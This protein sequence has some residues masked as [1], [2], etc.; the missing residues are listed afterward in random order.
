M[1]FQNRSIHHWLRFSLLLLIGVFVWANSSHV[2][3]AHATASWLYHGGNIVAGGVTTNTVQGGQDATIWLKVGYDGYINQARIYYT[4]NGTV[5]DGSYDTV[6]NGTKIT[7]TFDHTESDPG[8]TVAWWK[9]T[10]PAQAAGTYVR[11]KISTWHSGG[12]DIVYAESPTGKTINTSSEATT[13]AYYVGAYTTPTWVKD[14]TI[15]QVFIDR[16]FDGNT[17]NN[18]DCTTTTGGYCVNDLYKWNGGDLAGVQARLDYL[19]SLGVNTLWVTPIYEN[20]ITQIGSVYDATPGEIYNY[21]GY[22]AQD[23]FDVE[24]NF[25]TNANFTS[26]VTAAHAAGMKVI[27]DFVPNHSSNQHPYFKDASDNCTSSSYFRWYKFGNVNGQGQLTS[28]DNSKCVAGHTTWWG[29]NDTYANFFG[30]KEMPQID[31]DYGPAR[32]A[33]IDQALTWVNTYDVDG[34]RLDY[35]PGPSH[36]FWMAFRAAVKS[37]DPNIFLVGEV[38]T[39]GGAAERKSYEGEL[40]G[41]LAF[42]HLY[43][44]ENFFATRSTNVDTFDGDLAYYESYYNS[45]FILPSFLDNHDTDRFLFRAGGNTNRLKLAFI[46]QLT[47]PDAP[48]IFYGTEVGVSQAQAN[49]GQPERSRSRMPWA[50]YLGT[51]PTG[52]N[53]SQDTSIRD[54]VDTLI[55]LRNTYSALRTGDRVALYRH[56]A[57][58]TYAYRR[59]DASS[60]VLIALNNS[61]STRTLSIPNLAGTSL[62]WADGTV[63]ED[64]LSGRTFVVTAGKINI[65]LTAMQGAVLVPLAA[66]DVVPVTFTVNGYVTVS[67]ED[68]YVVGSTAETGTWNVNQAVKL[69]WIDS[70]TWSGTVYFNNNRSATTQ[71]KFI[72]RNGGS[73]TWESGS[74]RSCNVPGSGVAVATGNWNSTPGTAC[75]VTLGWLSPSANTAVTSSAGDNNG[76]QTNA[77]N[78]YSDNASF[79]VDTDS[80]TSTSTSCTVTTKD[81]HN[82]YNYNINVPSGT[83]VNGIEVRLDAKA[84]S[85]ASTPRLC[86]QLSWD[87]G[88]TWTTTKTTGN[89]TTS[90]ATYILGGAADNWGRTWSSTNFTNANFRVRVIMIAASTARDF[91]LDWIAV[92]VHYQ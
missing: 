66:S 88:T 61:D 10:I 28:Y 23:F 29:D 79:A 18:I 40:D 38:W 60:S 50:G 45:N 69:T 86:V 31:N 25:G 67:G 17:A 81:K 68:I 70:D 72:V 33:T 16:F 8:G 35:A 15:Y 89:L 74:N 1:T 55:G 52:W 42:D 19:Q 84:D 14:A 43:I 78:A 64:Q 24:D 12:G 62:T 90:E 44:F 46:T 58:G 30:V 63:V 36:S 32:Q 71:Y 77:A 39:G 85:T 26:L 3:A 91:S 2:P 13:F 73:T 83:T 59:T 75:V 80:G 82:Y 65:E 9:G 27:L 37:A 6:T 51:P 4:T 41:V 21:H 49:N 5:P 54:L 22:E 11:Y 56:N 48:V 53:S 76:Y 87:G 92:K 57:D 20:P 7:M 47:L 34:L